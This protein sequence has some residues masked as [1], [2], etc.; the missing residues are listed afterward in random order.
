[1][2]VG[3]RRLRPGQEHVIRVR[4]VGELVAVTVDGEPI[5]LGPGT[6]SGSVSVYPAVGSEIFVRAIDVV[7]DV[8]LATVVTG[9]TGKTR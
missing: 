5:A 6:L 1:M 7:G 3:S 9:P 2:V 8:D 4:Q